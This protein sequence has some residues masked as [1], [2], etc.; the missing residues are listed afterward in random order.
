MQGLIN[1]SAIIFEQRKINLF[2]WIG[3]NNIINENKY[4]FFVII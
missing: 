3:K 4:M 1:L 2:K